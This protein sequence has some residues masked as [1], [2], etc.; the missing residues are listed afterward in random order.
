MRLI[1]IV[2]IFFFGF[3]F[4]V[5]GQW[6]QQTV[7]DS[8]SVLRTID[9]SINNYCIATGYWTD[10]FTSKGRIVKTTNSGLNW[11]LIPLPDSIKYITGAMHISGQIWYAC[12]TSGTPYFAKST[13][14]GNTWFKHGS[15][16]SNYDY[17]SAMDFINENTGFI[18]IYEQITGFNNESNILKTTN[19]GENWTP[20]LSYRLKGMFLTLKCVNENLIM[21]AGYIDS[22]FAYDGVTYRTSN[23]GSSWTRTNW[24]NIQFW[25][26]DFINNTTGF[27][28]GERSSLE[29]GLIFKTTNEG[30][31]WNVTDTIMNC[32]LQG[33]EFY[34]S[35]GIG[36]SYGIR[37]I[38]ST[39]TNVILKTTN[40]GENWIEQ[41]FPQ[42]KMYEL[43]QSKMLSQTNYFIVGAKTGVG[44]GYLGGVVF[45]TTN[46][47]SVFV[48]NNSTTTPSEFSLKQ[49]YPNPFNP[50]TVIE[51]EIS[52]R[53]NV[54]LKIYNSLGKE[55]STLLNEIKPEGVYNV[56]FNADN[57]AGG[58]YYYVLQVNGIRE[59]K[60]MV[61][62]K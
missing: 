57:F 45:H 39:Y 40:Y 12:E 11:N 20:M 15:F 33:I 54:L 37:H 19:G 24:N 27:I 5:N 43:Y 60:K 55:V 2:I 36:I 42:S 10:G 32:P 31:N 46:G 8:I 52:K 62:I 34:P 47:G 29:R 7:P 28:C 16:P 23:G 22:A 56:K 3:N 61:L 50:E 18:A 58:V 41:S 59:T 48:E 38:G 30:L 53:S 9:F 6:V 26:M 14:N 25:D 35:T 51:F 44:T 13:D 21:T 1:N 17:I 49:N 4:S